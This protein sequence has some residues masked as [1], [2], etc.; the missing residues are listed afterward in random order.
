MSAEDAE[1]VLQQ[2]ALCRRGS[3]SSSY[4]GIASKERWIALKT[5]NTETLWQ[6]GLMPPRADGDPDKAKS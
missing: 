2:V 4:G 1:E 3:A 6:H 5:G